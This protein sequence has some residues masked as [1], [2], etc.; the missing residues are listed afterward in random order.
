MLRT[1]SEKNHLHSPNMPI[2]SSTPSQPDTIICL[3]CITKLNL[4]TN[5]RT[6]LIHDDEPIATRE[7]VSQ[8]RG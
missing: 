1:K 7:S 2:G 4:G 6:Y 3:A 5:G 8:V